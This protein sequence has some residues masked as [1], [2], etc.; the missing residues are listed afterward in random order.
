MKINLFLLLLFVSCIEKKEGIEKKSWDF[1]NNNFKEN[2]IRLLSLN[3]DVF[4]FTKKSDSIVILNGEIFQGWK[5]KGIKINDT[6]KLTEIYF[7]NDSLGNSMKQILSYTK[8]DSI[9]FQLTIT[10]KSF[11]NL[12]SKEIKQKKYPVEYFEYDG[13]LFINKKSVKYFNEKLWYK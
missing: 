6:L 3:Y 11:N 7:F 2:R 9:F 5:R 8:R 13:K 1:T 4:D 10:N 12:N